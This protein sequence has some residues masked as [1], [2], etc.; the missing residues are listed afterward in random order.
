M[1]RPAGRRGREGP[2]GAHARDLPPH[3]PRRHRGGDDALP[4]LRINGERYSLRRAGRALARSRCCARTSASRARRSPAARALRR[5]H[6]AARRR[7]RRSPCI[8]LVHTVGDREVTTIEG[9][10][11][12]PLD[13]VRSSAPTPC[14]AASARPDR[15]SR[16]P[17]SSSANPSPSQDE[18]RHAMSGNICRC[19]T[20]PKIEEAIT[21]WQ[22]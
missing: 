6:R 14:S 3:P 18:I 10:R 20:Y 8:T 17:R 4:E 7:A 5:L 22:D 16:P 13:R 9:L 2:H 15:S 11:D 21:T 1:V 12:H 19:G